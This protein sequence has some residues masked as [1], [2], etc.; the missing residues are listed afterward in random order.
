MGIPGLTR[1][2]EEHGEFFTALRL[3]DAHLVIDGS[4]L[5]HR[6]WLEGGLDAAR[7]GDYEALAGAVR[8]FFAAL[9]AC[10]LRAHVVLDGGREPGEAKLATRRQRARQRLE[11]AAALGRGARGAALP[12]LARDAFRQ[13][14]A[15]A[16]VPFVQCLGEADRDAAALARR[17]GC[18]LL[19]SDSD[20]Y[21]FRLPAGYCPLGHF[22]W[23]DIAGDSPE[24][25]IPARCFSADKLCTH[26]GRLDQ[27]LLPLFALL[28]GNDHGR[29]PAL[30]T[31]LCKAR[32]PT[33][34][35]CRRRGAR[36][37]RQIC[38]L[39]SWLAGFANPAA[40]VDS[41]V[42]HLPEHKREQVRELLHTSLDQYEQ[43]D[44]NLEDYFESRSY[45]SRVGWELELPRWMLG[46]LARGDLSPFMTD[47]LI[48]RQ[49]FLHVQVENMQRPSAHAVALPIRQVI[50]GLLLN[51]G[52]DSET[53]GEAK[54]PA[55]LPVV[56]EFD[57]FQKTLKKTFVQI[58][59]LPVSFCS[60]HLPLDKLTEVPMS[61]R[62]KLLLETLG[63]K[64]S[65]LEPIPSHLQLPLAVTC[66]WT[67]YSE[68]IVK[69]HH[70][71]ALLLGIVFGELQR[72]TSSPGP[73]VFHV[74]DNKVAYDHFLKWK[75][76]KLQ[77]TDLD[78][79]TAHT[80]CQWQCCLQMALYLNQLLSS[81][82]PEPD[83]T[84][85]KRRKIKDFSKIMA[86]RITE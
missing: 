15:G 61:D 10:R 29:L 13:V 44:G 73:E 31:F 1:Y 65:I 36:K 38:G 26:F 58:A 24:R 30:D 46:A 12:L 72:T 3:H 17:W 41:V 47:A 60:D 39:L 11:A 19:G 67:R 50:Y 63:V 86:D 68:P 43:A 57:R 8:G 18:P 82:L 55:Q 74:Q 32:L 21:T 49:T 85:I 66:Y 6:L 7:G 16:G 54:L 83:L 75:E 64:F 5:Y 76:K 84:R 59:V 42:H 28:S 2:V 40:A 77:N 37:H 79:D 25:Y 80:F 52:Q 22:Q 56:Q 69:L 33:R 4:S 14:L 78:L 70:L 48:L 34:S 53:C 81:P 62:L 35:C 27:A 45:E 23:R 71:K 9:R 20:F 51:A